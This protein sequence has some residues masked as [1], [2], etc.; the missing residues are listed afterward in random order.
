MFVHFIYVIHCI[1]L[2]LSC[3]SCLYIFSANTIKIV[4]HVKYSKM[5]LFSLYEKLL[6]IIIVVVI[7]NPCLL[8]KLKYYSLF[9]LCLFIYA[10]M[11][12]GRWKLDMLIVL[13]VFR[14]ACTWRSVVRHAW[15]PLCPLCCPG[16]LVWARLFMFSTCRGADR[17]HCG[18]CGHE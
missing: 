9:I 10:H 3:V 18:L 6:I 14:S 7:H 13:F 5:N 11:L 17:L 8:I 4:L 15:L 2:L 12:Q 1:F 16:R